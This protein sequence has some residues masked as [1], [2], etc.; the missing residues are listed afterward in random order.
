MELDAGTV[1]VVATLLLTLASGLFGAKYKRVLGKTKQVRGL[2][3][4][5]IVAAEDKKVTEKDFQ[6]I[7][8]QVKALLSD[9]EG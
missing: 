2:L 1:A 5:V 6:K 9:S 7:V 4:S 8:V 3:D